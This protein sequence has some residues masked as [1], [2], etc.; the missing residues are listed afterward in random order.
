M[1]VGTRHPQCAYRHK[2]R[3]SRTHTHTHTPHT[4]HT[5]TAAGERVG[6]RWAV[7]AALGRTGLDKP[8]VC[9]PSSL[10]SKFFLSTDRYCVRC[11]AK[12]WKATEG[13]TPFLDLSSFILETSTNKIRK[14]ETTVRASVLRRA[15]GPPWPRWSLCACWRQ[16]HFTER[17]DGGSSRLCDLSCPNGELRCSGFISC[18][19]GQQSSPRQLGTRDLTPLRS[20]QSRPAG[21]GSSSARLGLWQPGLQLGAEAAVVRPLSPLAFPGVSVF[22]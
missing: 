12:H 5:P 15:P 1:C 2:P 20:A 21:L 11:Y 10:F 22:T 14:K 17:E 3:C 6:T 18:A 9:W 16:L 8:H 19:A 7:A 13:K 4:P